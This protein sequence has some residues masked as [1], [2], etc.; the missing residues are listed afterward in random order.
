M[1]FAFNPF[2]GNFDIFRLDNF[3][4]NIIPLGFVI[5]IPNNQQ[6]IVSKEI[7]ILGEAS[8]VGE[9]VVI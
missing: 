7:D 8:I 1:S 2:T 5:F 6:M 9:L 4:Y 3:S